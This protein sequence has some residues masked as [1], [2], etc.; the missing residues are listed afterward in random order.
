MTIVTQTQKTGIQRKFHLY[1]YALMIY[2][3]LAPMEDLLTGKFGTIARYIGILIVMLGLIEYG[4]KLSF[5]M[6]KGNGAIIWLMILG[7]LSCIWALDLETA[8]NR[9][10]TYLLLPGIYLFVGMLH[11]SSREVDIIEQSILVG[12]ILAV[13]YLIVTG[14]IKLSGSVRLKL[15]DS[16]DP[17]NF[18][19]LLL[20]PL[21]MSFKL[22][23][24][25]NK[26]TKWFGLLSLLLLIYFILITGSRGGFVSVIS[27][28]FAY[29]MLNKAY[30]RLSIIIGFIIL[31]VIG[32][33]VILPRLPE[34]IRWRLF[35]SESYI[36]QG[37]TVGNRSDIWKTI[38]QKI[39]PD[40]PIWGVGAG[41][42]PIALKVYYGY[43][44]GVHNTYLNMLVEYG[45]FGIP[46]FLWIL[47]SKLRSLILHKNIIYAALLVGICVTIFF[48]DSYAKKFFWNVL[49]LLEI[50][51][52]TDN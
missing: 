18:A 16:N 17:N 38:V 19:A 24:N 32:W 6:Q 23:F 5:T 29:M 3:F 1:T 43:E 36:S 26:K 10:T 51:R 35:S 4:G 20:L 9:N 39:L 42:A 48:L 49:I 25:E 7:V 11:F 8:F 41:C 21:A 28:I 34:F 15:N 50:D 22:F 12:G 40:L 14:K 52:N 46:I 31:L 13:V 30:N 2:F 45:F 27:F 37:S 44:K 33:F 47:W